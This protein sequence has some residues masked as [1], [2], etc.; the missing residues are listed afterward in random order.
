VA[1]YRFAAAKFDL[2]KQVLTGYLNLALMEEKIRIGRDNVALL[3]ILTETASNGCK[4][5]AR[6]RTCSRHRSNGVW[7]RTTWRAWKPRPCPWGRCS[8]DAGPRRPGTAGSARDA[9]PPREAPADDARLIAVAVTRTR[10]GGPGAPGGRPQRR[11]GTGADAL[12]PGHQSRGAITGNFSQS[13]G[14]MVMLPTNIPAIRGAINDAKAM[15][16]ST[17]AL[18]RQARDDRAASFVAALYAMRN[19]NGR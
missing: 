8:R 18:T 5:A 19:A 14:T 9:A 1:G 7:R 17:Q 11:P 12:Y 15:L 4:P 2:Q 6:S 16:R 13:V 10:T 3:K